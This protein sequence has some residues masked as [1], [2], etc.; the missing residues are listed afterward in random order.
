MVD[1]T[2]DIATLQQY[3]TFVRY[4]EEGEIK[5]S[6]LDIRHIDA[7]GATTNNLYK[8]WQDVAD[9]YSLDQHIAM[10]V[11]GSAAML[12]KNNS[13]TQRIQLANPYMLPVHCY[14]HRLALSCADTC[15]GLQ[16]IRACERGLVQSWRFFAASSLKSHSSLSTNKRT[17]QTAS[18]LLRPAVRGGFRTTV[19]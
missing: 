17:R 1:E 13:L 16:T 2:T 15:K 3:I 10:S 5:V 7:N 9:I 19:P 14:A 6:F 12:G 4:V 11:D 18:D 8:Y